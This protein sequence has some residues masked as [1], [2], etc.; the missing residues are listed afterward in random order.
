[1]KYKILFSEKG[2]RMA[3]IFESDLSH[4]DMKKKLRYHICGQCSGPLNIAW[5]AERSCYILRCQDLNHNTITDRHKKTSDQ[6]EGE[7]IFK[8]VHGMNT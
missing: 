5:S 2:V 7:K 3:P 4:E 8:E 1:M 6:L